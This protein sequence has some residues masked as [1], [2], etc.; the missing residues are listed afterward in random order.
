MTIDARE[1]L[2]RRMLSYSHNTGIRS[3]S[4]NLPSACRQ[5]ISL[6]HKPTV[7]MISGIDRG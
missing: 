2:V 5:G 3:S 4:Y 7:L 1:I 6:Y